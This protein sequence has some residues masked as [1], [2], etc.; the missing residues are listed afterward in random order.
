MG[1]VGFRAGAGTTSVT[2]AG[3]RTGPELYLGLELQLELEM[4]LGQGLQLGLGAKAEIGTAGAG[5][6]NRMRL[7]HM[8]PYGCAHIFR[9][10]LKESHTPIKFRRDFFL[11]TN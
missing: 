6:D 9:T 2:R 3:D 1:V 7:E 10:S 5:A 4:G 11:C 8:L